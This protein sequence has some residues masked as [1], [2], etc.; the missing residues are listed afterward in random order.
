MARASLFYD[1][2]LAGAG[3]RF[4]GG[5]TA[6]FAGPAFTVAGFTDVDFAAA[7]GAAFGL[8]ASQIT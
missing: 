2:F 5:L 4:A 1:F 6:G 7:A 8:V 3:L